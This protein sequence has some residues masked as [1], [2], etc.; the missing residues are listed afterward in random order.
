MAALRAGVTDGEH[1]VTRQLAFEVDVV[2]R[3]LAVAEVSGLIKERSRE[4]GKGRRSIAKIY[5]SVGDAG[6]AARAC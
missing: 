4:G 5:E 2:L 3:D 1:H 6:N